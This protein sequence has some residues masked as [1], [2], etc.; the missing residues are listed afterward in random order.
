MAIYVQNRMQRQHKFRG[1]YNNES[2]YC[3]FLGYIFR[4]EVSQIEIVAESAS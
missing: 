4:V 3:G 2:S 1:F